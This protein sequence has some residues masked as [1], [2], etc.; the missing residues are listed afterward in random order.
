[1]NRLS[2]AGQEILQL[3]Q[4]EIPYYAYGD[5]EAAVDMAHRLDKISDI[6]IE[7]EES[8]R[9]RIEAAELLDE[10]LAIAINTVECD[11]LDKK[12][13]ELPWYKS[14]KKAREEWMKAKE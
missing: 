14:A 8:S 9:K 2:D 1:M 13:N 12:G 6:I 5:N 3:C 11:S 4:H 7:Y 10:A